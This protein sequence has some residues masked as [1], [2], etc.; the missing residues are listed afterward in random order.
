V[1]F[2]NNGQDTVVAFYYPGTTDGYFI[3]GSVVVT[4]PEPSTYALFALGAIGLLM[5]IRRKMTV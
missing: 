1:P 2:Y 5:V 4:I 3:Q